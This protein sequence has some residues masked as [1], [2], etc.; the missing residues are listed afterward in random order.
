[1]E[2]AFQKDSN[3]ISFKANKNRNFL[4]M[5]KFEKCIFYAFSDISK[6]EITIENPNKKNKV[7]I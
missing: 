2:Q 5:Q 4:I 3:L 7:L 6:L 1:L